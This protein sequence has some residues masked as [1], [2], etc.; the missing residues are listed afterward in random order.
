MKNL[1]EDYFNPFFSHIYIEKP[2]RNHSRTQDILAKF[3]A[4]TVI[5]INHYK[6]VFCRSKQSYPLQHCSQ[7]LILAAKQ[8]TF[9][10]EGAPVCQNFGNTNFYY[11]SCMMN[12]VFNCE[13]CFL[14]GMYP[15]ANMVI[16]V[17]LEDFFAEME[18]MLKRHPLYLCVSYDTDLMAMENIL[19]YVREWSLFTERH[20]D[21]KIEIRTKC[22]NKSFF[23]NLKPISNVIYAFTLSPQAVIE[24]YEHYTPSLTERISC[25]EEM[26]QAGHLVRLCFDPMIYLPGWN[27]HYGEMLEQVSDAMDWNKI[28]DVS[29]GSFRVSQGYLKKMRKQEPDSAVVW[30][31]FQRENGYYHYPDA[32]ME[33]MEF[34]LIEQLEKRISKE[35]IFRWKE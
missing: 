2:I 18:Q 12:C 21:L 32:L 15:S 20:T 13:Y 23:R 34:F 22:A 7:N 29:V 11:T 3:P 24:A 8:G 5:E 4:A 28:M 27:H 31:P 6:D 35:K 25:V 26:V 16:F 30:F 9:F 17:N 14:K 1:K 19:G 10:Y 33:Q